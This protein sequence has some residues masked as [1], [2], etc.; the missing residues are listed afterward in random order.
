MNRRDLMKTAA[1]G[2]LAAS[3]FF[4]AAKAQT[5]KKTFVLTPG[6]YSGSWLFQRVADRLIA[7]GHRVHNM[8][9][10]GL[11]ER[12]HTFSKSIDVDTHAQDIVNLIR[13]NDM[14]DVVLVAHS[15]AGIPATGAADEL[16][17]GPIGKL[18]YVD[19][20][21]PDKSMSW[22]DFHTEAQQKGNMDNLLGHGEGYRLLPW[23]DVAGITNVL[24]VTPEDAKITADKSTPMP[25]LTYVSRV[26]IKNGGYSRFG[27]RTYIECNAPA[28][29][30]IAQS[31]ARVKSEQGWKFAELGS[32]HMPMFSRPDEL[33]SL[34]TA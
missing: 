23:T 30:T 22:R 13:F 28:L 5:A 14:R 16:G 2:A 11:G 27:D 21:V 7:Q 1:A 15:Y 4:C 25:G 3:G 17:P 24:A 6:A 9:F 20:L 8:T 29:P 33:T 34:L 32:G 26:T 18:I 10:T 12:A 31:K 19:A